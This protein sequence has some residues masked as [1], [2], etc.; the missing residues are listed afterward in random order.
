MYAS[1]ILYTL[2]LAVSLLNQHIY[3]TDLSITADPIHTKIPF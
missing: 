1:K 3:V 2:H